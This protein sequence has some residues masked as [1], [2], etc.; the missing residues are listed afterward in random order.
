MAA[1]P[2]SVVDTRW[3]WPW[4]RTGVPTSSPPMSEIAMA[5]G[6]LDDLEVPL[7]QGEL[8]LLERPRRQGYDHDRLPLHHELV[9]VLHEHQRLQESVVHDQVFEPVEQDDRLAAVLLDEARDCLR[10]RADRRRVVIVLAG[11]V[12]QPDHLHVRQTPLPTH[13]VRVLARDHEPGQRL[14]EQLSQESIGKV[15]LLLL[16]E[17]AN[18]TGQLYG[19]S[20]PFAPS[21]PGITP[22]AHPWIPKPRLRISTYPVGYHLVGAARVRNDPSIWVTKAF[23]GISVTEMIVVFPTRASP[24]RFA[25][26]SPSASSSRTYFQNCVCPRFF[27]PN[28]SHT[29]AYAFSASPVVCEEFG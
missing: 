28:S 19:K 4:T 3:T 22:R 29:T 11:R 25:S 10:E 16:D 23:A 20:G 18:P 5:R 2:S 1:F 14:R 17:V 8:L 9:H 24:E 12:A 26:I 21:S 27:S 7:E 6:G 13:T 15:G